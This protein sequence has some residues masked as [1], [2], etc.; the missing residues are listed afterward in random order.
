[1]PRFLTFIL[2]LLFPAALAA[3]SPQSFIV[4]AEDLSHPLTFK[5]LRQPGP[6]E[7]HLLRRFANDKEEKI[8]RVAE[9][10]YSSDRALKTGSRSQW[11]C[12][13]FDGVRI[14][15]SITRS[16]IAYYLDVSEGFRT[17]NPREPLHPEMKFSALIYSAK[18]SWKESYKVDTA[19]F[20]NVYVVSLEL[21]WTQWCSALCAMTFA[22][23][24]NVVVKDDGSVLAIENDSCAPYV[25]S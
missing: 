3:Q 5:E 6:H 16:A 14:P 10:V 8:L 4:D 15:Y 12:S 21:A 20:R 11:W 9:A 23:S 1:M 19:E 24:R 2:F 13:S 25:V 17:K 7:Q 22:T 18:L